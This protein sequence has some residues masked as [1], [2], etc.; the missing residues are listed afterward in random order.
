MKRISAA[1]LI[2]ALVPPLGYYVSFLYSFPTGA[3]VI[4]VGL[5]F[6][7]ASLLERR[8]I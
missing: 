1:L 8:K 3:S 6:V 4:V 7:V 2:G 5:I